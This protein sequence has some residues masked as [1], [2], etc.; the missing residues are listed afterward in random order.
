[1]GVYGVSVEATAHLR[2]GCTH[3][4]TLKPRIDQR[5]LCTRWSSQHAAAAAA[6]PEV[7][8]PCRLSRATRTC[9]RVHHRKASLAQAAALGVAP[10][11]RRSSTLALAPRGA[12]HNHLGARVYHRVLRSRQ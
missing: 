9:E 2:F 3:R 6:P 7:V 10:L 11:G 8:L 12:L 1:M 5:Q 4:S